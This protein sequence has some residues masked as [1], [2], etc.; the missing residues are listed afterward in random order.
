MVSS[1]LAPQTTLSL[2]T[3]ETSSLVITHIGAPPLMFTDQ[4]QSC[5]VRSRRDQL[6]YTAPTYATLGHLEPN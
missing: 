4:D 2:S 1:L 5:Q 6:V 3:Q